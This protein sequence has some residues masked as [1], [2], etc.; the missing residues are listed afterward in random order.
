MELNL[1]NNIF[2]NANE[3][4]FIKHLIEELKNYLD[5]NK[6]SNNIIENK[7]DNLLK[8]GEEEMITTY[9]DK[10]NIERNKILNNYANKTSSKGQMYYIYS[11]NSKTQDAYNICICEEGKSHNVIEINKKEL[12]DGAEVGSVLRK[13][14]QNYTIDIEA[15]KDISEELSNLKSKVLKE[16][17]I[18][19]LSQR[20]EGHVYELSEKSDDRAWLFDITENREEALE[21]IEFPIELLQNAHEGDKF[22]YKKGKYKNIE[23]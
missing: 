21:E 4:A 1:N 8:N 3:N 19:L 2:N 5:N 22:V 15:T 9:R 14:G 20:K 17:D 23:K 7:E 11:E 18:Y 16:Q 6:I 10:M 13:K 12:P